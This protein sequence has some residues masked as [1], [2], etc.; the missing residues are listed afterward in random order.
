MAGEVPK[1]QF[2]ARKVKASNGFC[3]FGDIA[4][5]SKQRLLDSSTRLVVVGGA[6]ARDGSDS[7]LLQLNDR[8]R[9]SNL[10]QDV[11][12]CIIK[13]LSIHDAARTSVLSKQWRYI[14][15]M[16]THLVLDKL[17]FSRLISNKDEDEHQ[18]AFSRAIEMIILAHISPVLSFNLYIPPKLNQCHVPRWIEHFLNNKVRELELTNSEKSVF[19]I[20]SHIFDCQ[21]LVKLTL[22]TWILTPPV[23]FR[24][25]TNLI[26]VQLTDISITAD[27]TFGSQLRQLYFDRCSGIQHLRC[28]FINGNNLTKFIIRSSENI[29]WR[30]L[31]FTKLE[32]F[33]LEWTDANSN[34]WKS[35]NLIKLLRIVPT[36]TKLF[37]SGYTIQVHN[38]IN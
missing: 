7:E 28:Q 29:D 25:F 5:D 37:L 9:I 14:W 23:N 31:E 12:H 38:L 16:N 36:I 22:T 4:V 35:I 30:W 8:D 32:E 6:V 13:C 33:G 34:T 26:N 18:S 1:R 17:F 21:E 11:I 20:S 27:F 10:L 3:R 19:E 15:G 2:Y 24:S